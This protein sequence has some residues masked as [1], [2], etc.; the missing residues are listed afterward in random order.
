MKLYGFLNVFLAGCFG[1]VLIELLK[2]YNL[3]DS[4]NL[5]HYVKLWRYW[6]CTVAMIIAG[7][8]LTTLYGIE[9]VEALLAVNVGASAPL[10]IASLAQ[11]LPKTLPAERSAF[12]SKMPTLM[13][14][15]RNR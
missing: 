7:G 4:P 8:L 3:R 5:P 2:W 14:F 10:L 15:L 11:S 12:K 1:G 13:D 6:G 9:E